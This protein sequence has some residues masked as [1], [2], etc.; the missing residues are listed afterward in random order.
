MAEE[1]GTCGMNVLLRRVVRLWRQESCERSVAR[2]QR[3]RAGCGARRAAWVALLE[4]DAQKVA[5]EARVHRT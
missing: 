2:A 5:R 1:R 3:A 4:F